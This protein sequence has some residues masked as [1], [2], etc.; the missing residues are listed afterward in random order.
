MAF[1][2]ILIAA[3]RGA[4]SCAEQCETWRLFWMP[5]R[6]VCDDPTWP[7]PELVERAKTSAQKAQRCCEQLLS[8]TN[9]DSRDLGELVVACRF[10]DQL[11]GRVAM[12][13]QTGRISD[14]STADRQ[15]WADRLDE[16]AN[17]Y[18]DCWRARNKPSGLNEILAALDK[19]A[20][21]VRRLER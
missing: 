2:R 17:A 1:P 8:G 3:L 7:D 4:S 18:A 11:A 19:T 21:E 14:D 13:R 10:T 6:Q 20:D 16:A 15:A 9:R 5:W 12:A